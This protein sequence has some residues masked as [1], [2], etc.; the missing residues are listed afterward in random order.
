[1]YFG[2]HPIKGKWGVHLEAQLRRSQGFV[3]PQQSLIRPAVNYDINKSTQATFG[4]AYVK[5]Y[6]YGDFPVRQAFYEH[7]I[8]QQLVYRRP[9]KHVR[10]QY[11]GRF[12][13]RWIDV[14]KPLAVGPLPHQQWRL[15]QRVRFNIR[16]D[17]PLSDKYYL[18]F[19]NEL[20]LNVPPNRAPRM[21]DQNRAYGALG[22][23]AHPNW[24]LEMGYLHQHIAQRNN[25]ILEDNHT[26]Q[27]AVYSN[28][29]LRR[30]RK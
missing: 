28:F 6:P 2:D 24:R 26:I 8:Y 11:R 18:A 21:L 17:V 16:M 23:R 12:E 15:Q 27:L 5:T 22:Y 10:M 14:Q 4:Y 9:W 20:M 29:S 13:Q 25:R 1:M 7:R 19:Y 3:R 30:Y